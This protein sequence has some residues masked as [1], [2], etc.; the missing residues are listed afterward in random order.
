MDKNDRIL[1][2]LT[3]SLLCWLSALSIMHIYNI[4][5]VEKE[6]NQI[7]IELQT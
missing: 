1:L 6:L 5:K 7:K 3:I 2:L 4:N